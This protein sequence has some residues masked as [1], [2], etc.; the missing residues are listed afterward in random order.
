M[1]SQFIVMIKQTIPGSDAL[2][3]EYYQIHKEKIQTTLPEVKVKVV[4]DSLPPHGPHSPWNSP[5]Q[6]T[7]VG[8]LSLL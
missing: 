1:N 5:G 8:S 6:N 3:T 7:G 4:S 2:N